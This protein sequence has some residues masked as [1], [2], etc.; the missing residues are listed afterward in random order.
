MDALLEKAVGDG[1]QN[2]AGWLIYRL[3]GFFPK[4]SDLRVVIDEFVSLPNYSLNECQRQN[5][6]KKDCMMS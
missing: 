5:H 1:T 3:K 4:S 6:G 2:K